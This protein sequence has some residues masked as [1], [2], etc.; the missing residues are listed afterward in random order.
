[1][2]GLCGVILGASSRR[3]P[4]LIDGFITTA[5]ALVAKKL[6]PKSVNFMIASHLS[7]EQGHRLMLE[8]LGLNPM[9]HLK[10]RLGEGTGAAL[11][12][13]MVEAATKV[14]REMLSFSET[15]VSGLE[16]EK[17]LKA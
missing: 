13:H 11:C 10:M 9:V 7:G 12:M 8:L 2:A 3:V 17:I 1:I 5:A 16:E 15:G 4:V 6:Q 14:L